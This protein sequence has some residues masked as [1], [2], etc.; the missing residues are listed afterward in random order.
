MVVNRRLLM[1]VAALVVVIVAAL[2]VRSADTPPPA[3]VRARPAAADRKPPPSSAAPPADLNLAALARERTEPMDAGRNP[4]RFKPKPAPPP[5]P[6]PPA[7]VA[8]TFKG[9]D[10]GIGI[11]G[12][13]STAPAG[14][15]PP[16]P[17]TLKFIGIVQKADGTRI[18]VLT[19]G[20]RPI[21]GKE[22][23]DIEGRYK[24]LRIGEESIDIAYIDGRGRRSIAL[25][26]K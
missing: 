7:P 8:R 23:E 16:P 22:G 14:P 10:G 2:I 18:A 9:P 13:V 6:P 26:G 1:L 17:I 12:P 15:P 5:P 25:A 3:P 19:D 4:F 24:I 20:K 11:D 21:S